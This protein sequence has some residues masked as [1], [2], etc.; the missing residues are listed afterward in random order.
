MYEI[1]NGTPGAESVHALRTQ[2]GISPVDTIRMATLNN[3]VIL[4]CDHEVGSVEKGKI[5]DLLIVQGDPSSNISDTRNIVH[6]IKGGNLINR[7]KLKYP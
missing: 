3:A 7:S 4:R 1:P 2:A 6:V 5:A